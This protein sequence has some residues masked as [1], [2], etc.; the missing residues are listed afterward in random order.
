MRVYGV[1]G[2]KNAGKTG[3]VERLVAYLSARGLRVSTIKHAHHEFDVDADGTDSARH[4][5]AGAGEVLIAS[6]RRFA[7]MHELRGAPEPSL[8]ALLAHL[9][10]CD[11]V[12]VEGFKTARHPK[13]EAFRASEGHALMAPG[14]PSVRALAAD[15]PITGMDRPVFHLDD[16]A[17]IAAFICADCG[18]AMPEPPTAAMA[19]RS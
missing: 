7:L 5:A 9:S 13:I 2:W 18:L 1:T 19:E 15:A 6:A 16:T 14:D 3:L 10:P 11:L 4:R 8:D 17:A 12:L